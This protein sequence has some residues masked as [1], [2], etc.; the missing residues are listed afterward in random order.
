[1][2]TI[3]YYIGLKDKDTKDY[4][5]S[6]DRM[7]NTILDV[8]KDYYEGFTLQE[9]K[10]CYTHHTD[11]DDDVIIEDSIKV[12]VFTTVGQSHIEEVCEELKEALN[13]ECI[14]VEVRRSCISF[15]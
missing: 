15:I 6:R 7:I 12:T 1:M 11:I 5:Y 2:I 9:C 3:N 10:G 14:A 8:L 4:K 13:Q